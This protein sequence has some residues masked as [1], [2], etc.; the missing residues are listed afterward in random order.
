[1]AFV[2]SRFFLAVRCPPQRNEGA[3]GHAHDDALTVELQVDGRD[4]LADP[5]TFVYTPLPAERNR[6][7][8]ASAHFC[9]RPKDKPGANLTGGLF[10]ISDLPAGRC[11]YFGESGFAVEAQGRGWTVR[12]VVRLHPDRV[13]IADL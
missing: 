11:L 2:G 1:Y 7:R 5:G 8:A 3:P 12:R 13:V 9:P 4:L 6:Y 10:Q